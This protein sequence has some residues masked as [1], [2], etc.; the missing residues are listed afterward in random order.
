MRVI[1]PC[2]V[3]SG[4]YEV[5]HLKVRDC[6]GDTLRGIYLSPLCSRES[7][8]AEGSLVRGTWVESFLS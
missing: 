5:H 4:T 3:G 6:W 2:S 1:A 8:V 7:A